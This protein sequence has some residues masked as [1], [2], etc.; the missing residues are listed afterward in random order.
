MYSFLFYS[1]FQEEMVPFDTKRLEPKCFRASNVICSIVE[2]GDVY[3]QFIK[4]K[5]DIV[6]KTFFLF[7]RL[8]FIVVIN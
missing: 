8:Y 6:R 2:G 1:F 4:K 3:V 5:R 7:L